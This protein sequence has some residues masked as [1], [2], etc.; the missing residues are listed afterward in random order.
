MRKKKKL[1]LVHF[2]NMK[3]KKTIKIHLDKKYKT[4]FIYINLKL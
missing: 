3:C 1:M 4:E 2:S